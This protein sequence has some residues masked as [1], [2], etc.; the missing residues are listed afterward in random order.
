MGVYLPARAAPTPPYPAHSWPTQTQSPLSRPRSPT[1]K[2]GKESTHAR[3]AHAISPR[4]MTARTN[5]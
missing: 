4:P 5:P 1:G 3:S 2:Y